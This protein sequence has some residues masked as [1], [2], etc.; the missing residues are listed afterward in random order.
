MPPR[1]KLGYSNS[2]RLVGSYS[3]VQEETHM[4]YEPGRIDITGP[5]AEMMAAQRQRHASSWPGGPVCGGGS[6]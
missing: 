5:V 1:E 4:S 2:C 6:C 3:Q